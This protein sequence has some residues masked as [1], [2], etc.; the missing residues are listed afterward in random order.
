MINFLSCSQDKFLELG[1]QHAIDEFAE[2][3]PK[4]ASNTL[5]FLTDSRTPF[6]SLLSLSRHKSLTTY[7][8][9]III[10]DVL[11]SECVKR[12]I[13]RTLPFHIIRSRAPISLLMAQ[14]KKLLKE[15]TFITSGYNR[16]LLTNREK[17][18][19]FAI[20]NAY[21]HPNNSD[22][23]LLAAKVKSHYKHRIMKKLGIPNNVSFSFLI[24]S[25]GFNW[26]ISFL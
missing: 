16:G 15:G 12:F 7:H 26:I 21:R 2:P 13:P 14:I 8:R 11:N 25:C 19:F 5:V 10:S 22:N 9:L 17:S 3:T 20:Y 23:W 24:N 18:S 4:N 6:D 1:M